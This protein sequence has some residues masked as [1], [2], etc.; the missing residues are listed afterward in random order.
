MYEIVEQLVAMDAT[1]RCAL[2]QQ[3]RQK[4]LSEKIDCAKFLTYFIESYPQS[5]DAV[6]TADMSFWEKFK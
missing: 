2:Y 1:E 5:V 3:R 6:R 4:M